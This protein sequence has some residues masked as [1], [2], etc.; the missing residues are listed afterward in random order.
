[1]KVEKTVNFYL[2]IFFKY[3]VMWSYVTTGT[4]HDPFLKGILYIKAF[5]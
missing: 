1:M 3:L 4:Y 2:R 5:L